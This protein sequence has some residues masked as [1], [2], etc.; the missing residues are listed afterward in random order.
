VQFPDLGFTYTQTNFDDLMSLPNYNGIGSFKDF[1]LQNSNNKLSINTTVDG[2]YMAPNTHDYFGQNDI[3]GNDM[4]VEELVAYLINSADPYI[5][6]SQFDNDGDGVVDNVYIIYAGTGEATSGAPNDIWPHASTITPITVD[7]VIVQ[8]YACSNEIDGGSMT[9]IGTICHEFGHSLGLPDFYD[10]DYSGSGGQAEG[11]GSWDVMSGG[12]YNL[13]STSPASH[14]PLSKAMLGWINSTVIDA[15]GTY[16]LRPIEQDSL[17][18]EIPSISSN[19][20]FYLENRQLFG[21][22]GGIPNYSM[23]IYHCDYDYIMNY[24]GLNCI[25]CDPSHQGFDLEEAD[26]ETSNENGDTYPGANNNTSF[27]DLTFPSSVLWSTDNLGFPI[28]NIWQ[29]ILDFDVEFDISGFNGINEVAGTNSIKIFPSLAHDYVNITSE[30]KVE[31]ISIF[32]LQGQS[33]FKNNIN[34]LHTRI[35]VANFAAG[36]YFL[37]TKTASQVK[38]S[39][40]VIAH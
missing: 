30:E 24:Q 17:F 35:N 28:I 2:I 40:I 29:H 22:D 36:S 34:D 13:N 1:Y 20:G 9:G 31:E 12:N 23:L 25:N 26:G 11:L 21:F 8:S 14:N 32:N 6:F 19:E 15:N 38:V 3:N 37:K 4:N 7:G 18:Y 5:D 27:T 16:I 10:T 39:K 33:I